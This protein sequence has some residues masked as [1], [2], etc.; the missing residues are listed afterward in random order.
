MLDLGAGVLEF[1]GSYR[2][3]AAGTYPVTVTVT[4]KDGG[5]S[6]RSFIVTVHPVRVF[7]PLVSR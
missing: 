5:S 7:L 2:Y 6:S 1:T 3:P 4:D